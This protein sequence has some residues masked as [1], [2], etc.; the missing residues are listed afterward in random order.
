MVSAER[1]SALSDGERCNPSPIRQSFLT[2]PSPPQASSEP[3]V[4]LFKTQSLTASRRYTHAHV[5]I[6]IQTSNHYFYPYSHPPRRPSR[7]QQ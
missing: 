2:M 3:T 4:A 6:Q 7:G 5:H 1:E